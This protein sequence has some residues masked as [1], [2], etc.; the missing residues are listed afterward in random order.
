MTTG[1]KE[2]RKE[3]KERKGKKGREEKEGMGGR[4]GREEGRMGWKKGGS[5]VQYF[6]KSSSE[7]RH[8]RINTN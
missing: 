3:G 5:I 6:I 8:V 2:G 1:R 4:D 7:D